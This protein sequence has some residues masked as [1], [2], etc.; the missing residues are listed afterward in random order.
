MAKI[1][2]LNT[3]GL[4]ASLEGCLWVQKML[5]EGSCIIALQDTGIRRSCG[6]AKSC[7]ERMRDLDDA[8]AGMA[9]EPEHEI[10]A[11]GH[12]G[13]TLVLG[14]TFTS[15]CRLP[16][17][18]KAAGRIV[19]VTANDESGEMWLI[20]N[21]YLVPGSLS[22]QAKEAV[23]VQQAVTTLVETWSPIADHTVVL[24]DFNG[25]VGEGSKPQG[26]YGQRRTRPDDLAGALARSLERHG[27]FNV[28]RNWHPRALED[29]S[30]SATFRVGSW[31]REPHR[32][33][34]Q[35]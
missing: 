21:A 4:A 26:R 14:T 27:L 17:P 24:G 7:T 9:R 2:T 23:D 16:T 31:W 8:V 6:G 11:H 34:L 1:I 18:K 20:I 30:L 13:V 32:S 5:T 15:L 35:H 3:K 12:S 28:Y 29:S 22:E 33:H 19:A 10:G 25:V